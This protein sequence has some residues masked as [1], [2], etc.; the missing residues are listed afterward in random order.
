MR[1]KGR[2]RDAN[3]HLGSFWEFDLRIGCIDMAWKM[4]KC[5]HG[6]ERLKG[7]FPVATGK[8]WLRPLGP[9]RREASLQSGRSPRAHFERV[10]PP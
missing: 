10:P 4:P 2:K 5:K 3:G 7:M 1:R 6:M 8:P 9:M